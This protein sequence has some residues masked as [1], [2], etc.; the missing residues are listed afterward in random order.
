MKA[1]VIVGAGGHGRVVFSA[2]MALHQQIASFVDD[3]STEQLPT[4]L[5][6]LGTLDWLE[7]Q[8]PEHFILHNGI[9]S[10]KDNVLRKQ[11]YERFSQKGFEFGTLIHPSAIVDA[12]VKVGAGSQV[13]AGAILQTG[14]HVGEN[15]IIN[16]GVIVDHDGQ[17][18]DHIHLAPGV[19]LSGC[20]VVE[21][22]VFVGTG[23]SIIQ[24]ITLGCGSTIGAGSVI[25]APVPK[26][27]KIVGIH[28]KSN[29]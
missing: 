22:G 17:L 24:N 1:H 23:S 4:E 7:K 21:E 13:M 9:G 25:L 3:R 10:V 16:T 26:N 5:E 19:T 29:Q 2:L 14:V 15:C 18:A 28:S 20:A 11:I 8:N 6:I 12:S 27:S